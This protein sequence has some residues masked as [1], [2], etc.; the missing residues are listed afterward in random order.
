MTLGETLKRWALSCERGDGCHAQ[1][2]VVAA[3]ENLSQLA[4]GLANG[5]VI[6]YRGDISRDR[7]TKPKVVHKG[8]DPITGLGFR[9]YGKSTYLYVITP[10]YVEVYGTAGPLFGKETHERLD[11]IGCDLKCVAVSEPDQD[12][13]MARTEVCAGVASAGPA[14]PPH[15]QSRLLSGSAHAHRA[16]MRR[17]TA[18]RRG[19]S[20]PCTTTR[21]KGVARALPLMVSI[22][23]PRRCPREGPHRGD[24]PSAR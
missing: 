3:L 24:A 14:R 12:L 19:I 10:T 9:E 22:R 5:A 8:Q 20:R 4:I 21:T 15:A 6:L 18:G 7:F 13:I 11:D 16:R 1:V 23:P 17:E 2:S